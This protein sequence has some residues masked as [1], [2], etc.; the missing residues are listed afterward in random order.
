[1]SR[2]LGA[3]LLVITCREATA[4]PAGQQCRQDYDCPVS[5]TCQQGVCVD[6]NAPVTPAPTPAPTVPSTPAPGT[7]TP[8]PV[9]VAPVP[10]TPAPAPA[11][12]LAPTGVVPVPVKPSPGAVPSVP[13]EPIAPATNAPLVRQSDGNA[14]TFTLAPTPK[15]VVN[16]ALGGFA[17]YASGSGMGVDGKFVGGGT[18]LS[19]QAVFSNKPFPDP[20]GGNWNAARVDAFVRPSGGAL[21][22]TDSTGDVDEVAGIFGIH[23]GLRL[24]YTYFH[25]QDIDMDYKQRG[26]GFS[27]AWALG[28]QKDWVWFESSDE[29]TQISGF[30]HGPSLSLIFPHYSA[31]RA[32][33]DYKS[34]TIDIGFWDPTIANDDAP[35]GLHPFSDGTTSIAIGGGGTF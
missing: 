1:M 33:V 27:V 6:P 13:S 17:Y 11:P 10:V 29:A 19:A 9:P 24:G 12:V 23:L 28:F 20:D 5:T 25:M 4:Q 16:F 31:H 22:F 18:D 8:A 2:L 26:I 7:S 32:Y 34:F 30:A 35:R 15:W 3:I 21:F 14:L